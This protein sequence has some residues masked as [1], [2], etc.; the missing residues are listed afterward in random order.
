M[1][2]YCL[3]A[4]EGAPPMVFVHGFACA[5]EDWRLQTGHFSKSRSVLAC[6]LRGHGRTPGAAGD[7]NIER[8]GAD[9]AE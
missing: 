9:V 5:H 3:R 1:T 8:Y 6:D 7:C 4:G 2:M